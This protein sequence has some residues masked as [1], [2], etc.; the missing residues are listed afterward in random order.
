MTTPTD[1][2]VAALA[3]DHPCYTE[4]ARVHHGRVHLAVAPRCNLG[5]GYCERAIGAN[6]DCAAGPGTAARVLTPA[7][8]AAHVDEIRAE[9]W[10]RVVGIAGPGEP[11]ANPATLTT[12][13]LLRNA[14]SDLMLCL[15]TNGLELEAALP[16]LLDAG[17]DSLTVTINTTHPETAA[18]LYDWAVIGGDRFVGPSA[19]PEV[20]ARQWRGLAAAVRAGL[21]VKVNSVL[22][23]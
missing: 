16:E 8:A 17:L 10:L 5:C 19:A 20:L 14:H 23:P 3:A 13:R 6:A 21:L 15:S 11:L 4:T 12:L 1:T 7:E 22:I 2:G 9:G 18:Q